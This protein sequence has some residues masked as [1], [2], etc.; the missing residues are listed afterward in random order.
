MVNSLELISKAS[1]MLVEADTGEIKKAKDIGFLGSGSYIVH[2]CLDCGKLR[3]V[4]L[5]KNKPRR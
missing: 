5:L 1:Q 4:Q 2:A 3:W